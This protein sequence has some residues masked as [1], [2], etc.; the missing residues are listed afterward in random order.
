MSSI[1]YL[2]NY[3]YF[4]K[5]VFAYIMVILITVLKRAMVTF[6]QVECVIDLPAKVGVVYL[7]YINLDKT[8]VPRIPIPE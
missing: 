2:V 5:K 1:E 6:S 8:E 3:H 4:E 7:C